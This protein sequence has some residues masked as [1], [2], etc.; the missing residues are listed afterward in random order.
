VATEKLI[1]LEVD[2][3]DSSA[4]AWAD[5]DKI[6]QV[7]MNLVG[8]A[9]K[10]TPPHGKVS[11]AVNRNGDQWMQISVTDTGP[12]IPPEEA[13][14]IFDR[15]YQIDQTGKQKARGTGLGLAISKVL[16]EMHGGKIWLE[17]AIGRGS[18]FSFTVPEQQPLQ[19]EMPAQ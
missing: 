19:I 11:I 18:T 1:S 16:V 14:K 15:F 17:S 13:G 2:S 8:N 6:T 4:T 10:F 7:L 5:R 9:V 3:P 12:G